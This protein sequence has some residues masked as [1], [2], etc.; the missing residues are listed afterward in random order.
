MISG[1]IEKIDELKELILSSK[2]TMVLTGAGISTNS[3]IPDFRSKDTGLWTKTDPMEFLTR[4]V[5]MNNPKK[6]YDNILGGP[7]V[8]FKP[9]RGHYILKEL[10]DRKLIDGVIT[11]NI[12]RLH[13]DAGS[14]IVYEVHGNMREGYCLDCGQIMESDEMRRKIESG[15]I[16]PNCNNCNGVV[17][18]SIVLF[19]DMLPEEFDM[20]IDEV[21]KSDLLIVIGSSLSVSPINMLPRLAKK[22]VIINREATLMDNIADI[23]IREDASEALEKLIERL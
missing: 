17:R 22:L 4:E 15:E 23:C 19:G 18:T 2:K 12:D 1:N 3:G 7:K 10:E 20:A 6:L 13:Q 9:N 8:S 16:P 11:Q 21:E 14:K 5:L